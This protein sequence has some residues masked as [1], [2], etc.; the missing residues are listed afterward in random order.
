MHIHNRSL[1]EIQKE[2]QSHFPG[3]KVGAIIASFSILIFTSL[4]RGN[5]RTK[6]LIGIDPCSPADWTL[7]GVFIAYSLGM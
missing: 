1:I 3:D 6:S 7:Y 2:E 5:K 4:L